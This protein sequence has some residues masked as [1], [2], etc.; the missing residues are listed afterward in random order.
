MRKYRLP[1]IMAMITVAL[2]LHVADSM[3]GDKITESQDYE[4]M[5]LLIKDH[6]GSE[7]SMILI[8]RDTERWCLRE[9]L[10]F[11]Q[12][13]WPKLKNETIDSLIVNNS[14]ET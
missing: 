8:N 1:A 7:F 5:S 6:Y 10:G 9:Q 11:L 4:V 12:R 13:Q 14:G 3:A 2:L